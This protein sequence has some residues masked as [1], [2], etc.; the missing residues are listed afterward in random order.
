MSYC[1]RIQSVIDEADKPDLIPLEAASHISGC[2]EC[3]SFADKRTKLQELMGLSGRV[4]VPVN[5]N[6]VLNERLSRV[7]A[8]KSSW[9]GSSGL[10]RLGTATAGLAVVVLAVQ[11]SGLISSKP[12]VSTS[13]APAMSESYNPPPEPPRQI[14][15]RPTPA[16]NP[17]GGRFVRASLGGERV[18]A[19]APRESQ[20]QGR[21][22]AV[23][24]VRDR[25]REVEVPMIPFSIGSQQSVLN[26]STRQQPRSSDISY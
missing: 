5:F 2:A 12:A 4:T 9:F 15:R 3:R 10:L 8:Q 20:D 17:G 16:M 14:D 19:R 11:Y 26:S 1:T 13:E 24:I 23:F 21:G 22:L 6:V 25:D 18:T 7:K